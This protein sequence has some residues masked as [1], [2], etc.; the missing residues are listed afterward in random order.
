MA[1]GRSTSE[2]RARTHLQGL[3]GLRQALSSAHVRLDRAAPIMETREL[4][5]PTAA[6]ALA[7]RLYRPDAATAAGP[8]VVFFHGGGFVICDVETHDSLCRWLAQ[9]SGLPVLSVDYRLAPEAAFPAQLED[10]EAATRWAIENAGALGLDPDR[11]LLGGDSA[12]G[13]ICVAVAA[14]LNGERAGAIAGLVLLYPLLELGDTAWASSIFAHARIL[15]RV[16]LNYI[17]NQLGP[18]SEAAA[19]L[20]DTDPTLIPPTLIATGGQLDPSRPDAL[21]LA[22]RLRA[23]GR[24]PILLEYARLPHG[25]GSITHLTAASRRAMAEIGAA[26]RLLADGSTSEP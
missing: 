8:G 3:R 17:R 12:G 19:S 16:T 20:I 26:A 18:A 9:A 13:Y 11:L 25:F 10:G 23:A 21:R 4:N 1:I 22:Q 24:T 2:A 14:K 15:G 6:G 5:I 7:A